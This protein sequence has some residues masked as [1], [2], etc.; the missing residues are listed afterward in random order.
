VKELSM[1]LS[2]FLPNIETVF[3]KTS[4]WSLIRFAVWVQSLYQ[5]QLTD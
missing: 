5:Y 3:E 4:K 1:F 2:L